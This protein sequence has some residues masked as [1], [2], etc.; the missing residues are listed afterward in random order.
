MISCTIEWFNS[1]FQDAPYLK[2][3]VQI[4]FTIALLLLGRQLY[5]ILWSPLYYYWEDPAMASETL[6]ERRK[7]EIKS[8]KRLGTLP[9]FPN[10]WYKIIC[11]N[12]LKPGEVK[13]INALGKEWA[14]FRTKSGKP[15]LIGAY[16]PHLGADLSMGTVVG[17]DLVC[18]F[19]AFHFDTNGVC[20]KIPY[21]EDIPK[22][23]KCQDI[24]PIK[25]VNDAIH[26]WFDVDG[27]PPAWEVPDHFEGERHKYKYIARTHHKVYTHVQEI[28]ENGADIAHLQVVHWRTLLQI[29]VFW[30]Q[31]GIKWEPSPDV[32][33]MSN[34]RV[35]EQMKIGNWVVPLTTLHVEGHHVG[36]G[37]VHFKINTFMG[38][39]LVCHQLLP[40]E[41]FLQDSVYQMWSTRS[42]PTWFAKIAMR[43]WVQQ[44]EKDIVIWNQK[45]FLPAAQIVKNDGPIV[46]YR[47]WFKQFYS[48]IGT[49]KKFDLHDK[50][51]F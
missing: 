14:V 35:K 6:A 23:I 37:L 51:L 43:G 29:P 9:P 7:R 18:P 10:G 15:G 12:E 36:P 22:A 13:H 2:I 42:M 24:L 20:S 26:V 1:Q 45:Q 19:H 32:K 31:W 33:H 3:G 5:Q 16:C 8:R 27:K 4:L 28:H 30:H 50:D 44:Y 41:G 17:E 25:E 48:E 49:K 38:Q 34:F 40:L 21:Q 47:R 46:Q 39:I 11:S